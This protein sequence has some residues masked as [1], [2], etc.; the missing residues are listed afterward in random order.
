[1]KEIRSAEELDIVL[2]EGFPA[3]DTD[4]ILLDEELSKKY[5]TI[6]NLQGDIN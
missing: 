4:K 2:D 5:T 1:M 6:P 3:L